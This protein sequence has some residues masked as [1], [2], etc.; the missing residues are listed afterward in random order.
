VSEALTLGTNQWHAY[1][2]SWP[3]GFHNSL[4]KSVKTMAASTKKRVSIG[5][6][7]QSVKPDFVFA[8]AVGIM[9]STRET[10]S[11]GNLFEYELSPIPASL[12]D[13]DG[14]MRQTNKSVLKNKL[15][16]ECSTR[17][18]EHPKVLIIDGC[19]LLWTVAWPTPPAKVSD[20]VT[21]VVNSIWIR[22]VST[23]IVHI[24]FDRYYA[25]SIK[26]TCRS[27]RERGYSRVIKLQEHSPLP[28]QG[29]VLNACS[30]SICL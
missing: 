29:M 25:P 16:V 17:S 19:A 5:G 26:S 27:S 14:H 18:I 23:A 12:F 24:V 7:F 6:K 4:K 1:E 21:A 9:A 2:E 28:S 3:E 13:D 30:C 11:L 15:K 8:R 20:Y 22:I 10:F